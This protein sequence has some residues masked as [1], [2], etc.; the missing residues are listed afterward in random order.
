MSGHLTAPWPDP[1]EVEIQPE[2]VA[3]LQQAGTAFRLIDC[4]EPDEWD[5]TRI[6]GA[7][8]LPLTDF[9]ARY[10]GVLTNPA[11]P[12]VIH[13]H[14][15]MRSAKATLFLRQKGYTSVWSMARGIEG[16]SLEVDPAV[17]RY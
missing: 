6:E 5:T 8:L 9:A 1:A 15:G 11:E 17:A 14:H 10:A 16:W 4:R 12:I 3:S 2:S 7:E 13:C